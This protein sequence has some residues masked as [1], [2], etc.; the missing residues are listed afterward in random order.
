MA[1]QTVSVGVDG[2]ET[3]SVPWSQGITAHRA[4]ELAYQQIN[5][6]SKFTYALQYYGSS[7][8]YMVFMVNN[9]YDTFS[10]A[11]HPYYYWDFLVNGQPAGKGVDSTVLQPGDAV[12]FRFD[13]Y[14]P[15]THANTLLGAKHRA[16]IA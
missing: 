15:N 13:R 12:S 6:S 2:G 16:L 10:A 14:D 9:T 11:A 7:L 3:A 1:T 4:L 5:N 8:G